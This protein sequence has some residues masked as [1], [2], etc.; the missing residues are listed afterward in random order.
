M[1]GVFQMN[2][3]SGRLTCLLFTPV[4]KDGWAEKAWQ[5]DPD[6]IILDLE[7]SIPDNDKKR[8][9]IKAR[10]ISEKHES[11]WFLRINSVESGLWEEDLHV[12][13]NRNICGILVPKSEKPQD[14]IRVDETVNRV[15][16]DLYNV[17][18]IPMLIPIVETSLGLEKAFK[19]ATSTPNIHTLAFGAA[20]FAKDLLISGTPAPKLMDLAKFRIVVAS[21]AAGLSS[22]HDS[23]FFNVEDE[24]GLLQEVMSAKSM[25]FG[26]K[27]AIH[28]SQIKIIKDNFRPSHGEINWALDVVTKF[29]EALQSGSAAIRV[30]NEMV[31]YPV[32]R[33]AKRI[34]MEY[35]TEEDVPR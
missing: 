1:Y 27:H 30:N 11:K 16:S 34:V 22:P 10:E 21:R 14:I 33:R 26:G 31:D 9:R 4:L 15:F 12:A 5:W 35:G 13:L 8:A 32:Y 18:D 20:D 6:G 2:V 24:N 29:E 3:I 19:V 17:H 25:A 23:P 28:P 7:D